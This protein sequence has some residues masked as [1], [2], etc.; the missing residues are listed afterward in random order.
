MPRFEGKGKKE[1][2]KEKK[3]EKWNGRRGEKSIWLFR[4]IC[5]RNLHTN[6]FGQRFKRNR[7]SPQKKKVVEFELPGHTCQLNVFQ[8]ENYKR[9]RWK[10][11]F[12]MY[13]YLSSMKIDGGIWLE[14]L[15][16]EEEGKTE[17]DSLFLW[18][19]TENVKFPCKFLFWYLREED[20]A[21]GNKK[22]KKKTVRDLF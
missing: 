4:H 21:A 22:K 7:H 15:E 11:E 3:N 19:W 17:R 2:R 20:I 1:K 5:F 16:E 12:N 14:E 13:I 6:S 18:Y 8:S 10:R 9:G